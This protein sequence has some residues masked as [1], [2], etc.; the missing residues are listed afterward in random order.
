M[1]FNIAIAALI[2]LAAAGPCK[3]R[4]ANA[5]L[6]TSSAGT[7]TSKPATTTAASIPATSSSR[8]SSVA[9]TKFSS[10]VTTSTHST[11]AATSTLKS[12]SAPT[13]V[14]STKT[15]AAKTSTQTSTK[16]TSTTAKPSSTSA[17]SSSISSATSSTI[18]IT[19]AAPTTT[20]ASSTTLTTSS[21]ASTTVNPATASVTNQAA[22]AFYDPNLDDGTQGRDPP[23]GGYECFAGPAG[24]FPLMSTWATFNTMWTV[25]SRDEFSGT[26]DTADQIAQIRTAIVSVSQV[27]EV[28]PRII[29][30]VVM[31]ESAGAVDVP[32]TQSFGGVNNCGLMQAYNSSS[33]DPNNSAASIRQM[34]VDGTQGTI[35]GEGLVQLLNENMRSQGNVYTA[36]RLYNSGSAD[37]SNLSDGKGANPAYVSNIGNYLQGWNGYGDGPKNCDFTTGT[38]SYPAAPTN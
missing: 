10:A 17:T 32:C 4:S 3:P 21:A 14:S 2:G 8:P 28:D 16:P 29:L 22:L 7:T 19:T 38:D 30:A 24:N 27:A 36:L 5:S 25:L 15:T 35:Y 20:S 9:S 18:Q 1:R 37:P 33:Y 11:K 34:I 31:V 13:T 26:H 6:S 23:S 12:S